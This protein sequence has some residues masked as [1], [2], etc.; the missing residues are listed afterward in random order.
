MLHIANARDFLRKRR[1]RIAFSVIKRNIV[2]SS[3]T[4]HPQI[5]GTSNEASN[6]MFFSLMI[7]DF[8][9]LWNRETNNRTK[10][11]SLYQWSASPRLNYCWLYYENLHALWMHAYDNWQRIRYICLIG[12]CLFLLFLHPSHLFCFFE[13]QVIAMLHYYSFFFFFCNFNDYS[14]FTIYRSIHTRQTGKVP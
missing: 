10:L 7:A 8:R 4:L 9:E 11:Y 1:W 12:Y 13:F 14:Y 2:D 3:C 6:S 5:I